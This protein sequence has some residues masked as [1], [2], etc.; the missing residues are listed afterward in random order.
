M[1]VQN[2]LADAVESASNSWFDQLLKTVAEAAGNTS[3]SNTG[4]D[5]GSSNIIEDDDDED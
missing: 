1:G 3:T 2:I 4:R 5:F